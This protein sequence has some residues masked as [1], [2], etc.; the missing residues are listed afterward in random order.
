MQWAAAQQQPWWI[1]F[2]K[3]WAICFV[4][5]VGVASLSFSSVQLA[6]WFVRTVVWILGAEIVDGAGLRSC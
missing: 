4:V 2:A 5:A 3:R 6:V 1:A